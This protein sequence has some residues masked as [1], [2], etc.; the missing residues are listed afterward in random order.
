MVPLQSLGLECLSRR[1]APEI[2]STGR[3]LAVR[4]AMRRKVAPAMMELGDVKFKR[5]FRVVAK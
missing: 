1:A 4:K 2:S 5:L 3:E